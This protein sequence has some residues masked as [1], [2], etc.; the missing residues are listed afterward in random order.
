MAIPLDVASTF[1]PR[2]VKYRTQG[3]HLIA[4]GQR[5][6]ELNQQP[7]VAHLAKIIFETFHSKLTLPGK[8]PSPL[9]PTLEAALTRDA[10]LQQRIAVTEN[11]K[12]RRLPALEVMLRRLANDAMRNEPV[13]LKLML[14]LFDRYGESPET[15]IRLDEV[16]AEDKAILA[17]FLKE[18]P[19]R[20]GP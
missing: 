15:G 16:L 12:T 4:S 11:G 18:R 9:H 8:P 13:A 5:G 14:S 17:N 2:S 3:W 19:D 1:A 10:I 20:S 7:E 6:H